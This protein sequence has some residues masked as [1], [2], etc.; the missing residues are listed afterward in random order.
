M[1]VILLTHRAREADVRQSLREI[2][3]MAFIAGETQ[4]IRIERFSA[5]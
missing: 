1:Q 3:P 5:P 2:Q 4:L